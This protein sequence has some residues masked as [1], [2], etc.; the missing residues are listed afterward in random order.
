MRPVKL[1]SQANFQ[2]V[3]VQIG[4]SGT[5]HEWSLKKYNTHFFQVSDII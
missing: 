2:Q 4:L 1:F 5:D 3:K